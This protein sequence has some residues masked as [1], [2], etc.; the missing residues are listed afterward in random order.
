MQT[1]ISAVITCS[2]VGCTLEC[3]IYPLCCLSGSFGPGG[4][5]LPFVS[6]GLFERQSWLS[7]EKKCSSLDHSRG[8]ENVHIPSKPDKAGRKS[9]FFRSY[10]QCRSE[11]CSCKSPCCCMYCM[12]IIQTLK[13]TSMTAYSH[14]L[15]YKSRNNWTKSAASALPIK[16][17]FF[18]W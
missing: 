8:P 11:S 17:L 3:L 9:L 14:I 16:N 15:N 2:V 18:M 1:F 5:A 6:S 12:F 13:R 7:V 4:A 10:V